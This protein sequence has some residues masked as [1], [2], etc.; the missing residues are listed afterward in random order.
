MISIRDSTEHRPKRELILGVFNLRGLH[1]RKY[2]AQT[3]AQ[4]LG[5]ERAKQTNVPRLHA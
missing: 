2:R 1:P 3:E 4:R 5:I